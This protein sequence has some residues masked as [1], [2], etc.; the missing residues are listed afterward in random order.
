MRHVLGTTTAMITL[1][2][3]RGYILEE[4]LA[5][6]LKTSGYELLVSAHQDPDA[7]MQ[8]KHGLVVRGRGANHQADVLGELVLP[9]PFSLPI[10][11]FVEAKYRRRHAIGLPAVR[12]AH[13]VIHDINQQ[14]ASAAARRHAV[15]MRR[16]QYQYALFSATG[17]SRDAQQYALAQQ[18]SLIDLSS[19]VFADLRSAADRTAEQMITIANEFGAQSFP[20]GRARTA[21]RFALGTWTAFDPDLEV[22]DDVWRSPQTRQSLARLVDQYSEDDEGL[23]AGAVSA[24]FARIGTDL[25]ASVERLHQNLLLGFPTAPFVLVL[26]PNHPGAFAEHVSRHGT[27]IR[28]NIR[29]ATRRNVAE[30]WV[31]VPVNS[32]DGFELRFTLPTLLAD[33]ILSANGAAT[34]RA[35]DIRSALL[36][37][38]SIIQ[39]GQLVQLLYEPLIGAIGAR[40]STLAYSLRIKACSIRYCRAGSGATRRMTGRSSPTSTR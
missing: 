36:S 9:T 24:S 5:K 8:D 19:S 7:L 32:F 16:Y 33:W 28:V 39:G 21:L 30:G 26:R 37:T 1:E 15:P 27:N 38:I 12:N 2:A 17:F 14:Y 20:V 18:I 11:L 3:L 22:T 25:A 6:L 31:I 23:P 13:G 40:N 34:L 4:L 29:F 35:R 10:R